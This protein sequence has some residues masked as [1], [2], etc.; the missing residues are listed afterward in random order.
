M[1]MMVRHRRRLTR[2]I[3]SHPGGNGQY[4]KGISIDPDTG[5]VSNA[6]GAVSA[7]AFGADSAVNADAFQSA[8]LHHV[9]L[10]LC[11]VA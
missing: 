6:H 8:A 7:G 3:I 10:S 4:A 11:A 5:L 2:A 1:G 9:D